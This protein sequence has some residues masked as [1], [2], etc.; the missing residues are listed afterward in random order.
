MRVGYYRLTLVSGVK[1]GLDGVDGPVPSKSQTEGRGEDT[2]RKG[3][4]KNGICLSPPSCLGN[5]CSLL[6]P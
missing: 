2:G 4:L 3:N 1:G 5:S 6:E